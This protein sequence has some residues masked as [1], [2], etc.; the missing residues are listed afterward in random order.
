MT[1]VSLGE[2][3]AGTQPEASREREWFL[4]G[5]LVLQR[6]RLV[7]AAL[8]DDSEEATEAR[9]EALL[10]VLWLAGIAGVLGTSV[11][12]TLLDDPARDGIVVAVWAFVG[13]GLYGAFAYWLL[14]ACVYAAAR[15]LGGQG[16]YR[17]ARHVVGF[18]AVPFALSLFVVWPIAIAAY[19]GDLFRAGG[20]DEGSAA[21]AFGW[22]QALVAAWCVALL[23][24]G[25]RAV[26]GWSWA[27]SLA[28]VILALSPA[29]L[30]VLAQ[31]LG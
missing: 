26:H 16:S 25:I 18:A 21:S 2:V 12:Q 7:F 9:Q 15:A 22:A 19:G 4:R 13:G 17:R 3:S 6:P 1:G 24:I 29:A 8:R 23:A 11:A 31:A 28:T 30:F 10:A 5:L 14:G 27:R 20:S